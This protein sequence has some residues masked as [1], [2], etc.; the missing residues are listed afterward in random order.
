MKN[1]LSYWKRYD[2][3][4]KHFS[5]KKIYEKI[6]GFA[7]NLGDPFTRKSK[8][9]PKFKINHYEYAA[10]IAF[11]TVTHNS[12]YRDMELGSELYV[13]CH[14]DHSTFGKNF[15]KTPIT[16]FMELLQM[17]SQ[18]LEKLLGTACC[19]IADSTG[20]V[21]NT[22]YD[23]E[24]QGK[25]IRRRLDYK[26]HSL[27]GY[28]PD[29]GITYIKEGLGTDKHTSDSGGAIKML[30]NYSLGW[31][32]FLGDSGFDF[33]QL[34]NKVREKG[35]YP[36]IKPRK[37]NAKG[38]RAKHRE[39]FIESLYKELRH[40]VETIFGGLENK[41]LLRTKLRRADT[42]CKHGV[43]LQIRHNLQQI[44]KI[45]VE[46]L[47]RCIYSTNSFCWKSL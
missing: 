32:Y 31:A 18:F 16:Y 37:D 26:A 30:K 38:I 23:T 5:Y 8:K 43:V 15:I 39:G 19:Y 44:M 45:A 6:L 10:Y 42:I 17:T 34:H 9:G 1:A 13:R 7:K 46:Q 21:T 36:L 27:V 28:Y 3:I 11:E 25:S 41:G 22:F 14:I 40:V 47:L 4:Y 12:P 2:L 29:K 35:L 20:I 24:H 33:T